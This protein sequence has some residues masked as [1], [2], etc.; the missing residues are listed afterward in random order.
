[1]VEVNP[2]SELVTPPVR[3]DD[4]ASTVREPRQIFFDSLEGLRGLAALW[5]MTY[6]VWLVVGLGQKRIGGIDIFQPFSMGGVGVDAFFVLS[7]FLLAI[8]WLRHFFQDIP[9]SAK[10]YARRRL[11][12]I[13][14]AYYASVLI[15]AIWTP[16][17][18]PGFGEPQATPLVLLAHAVF[19]PFL[20][21]APALDGVY[22]SLS[23][24]V[25]FYV[26]LPF[27]IYFMSIV[28]WWV[29]LGAL[30]LAAVAWHVIVELIIPFSRPESN[31]VN[32]NSYINST[33]LPGRI[34][35]F[36]I[37]IFI[38]FIWIRA[39]R[40][41]RPRLGAVLVVAGLLALMLAIRLESTSPLYLSAGWWTKYLFL[42]LGYGIAF[43]LIICGL[44]F[45]AYWFDRIC[46]VWP[47]RKLGTISYS[48]YLWHLPIATAIVAWMGGTGR[49]DHPWQAVALIALATLV[50]STASYLLV[51]RPF[52][53]G[54]NRALAAVRSVRAWLEQRPDTFRR[55]T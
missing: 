39:A 3:K 45:G 11:F 29:G 23:T 12:R 38:A 50:A 41:R 31:G 17:A 35:Q 32:L 21:N 26:S 7:G 18:A 20:A 44:V 42:R 14:P 22:W 48:V 54:G 15:L 51:E 1:M 37:G 24:E 36:A 33:L 8:P 46:S 34:G 13:A 10:K 2:T 52:L 27:L 47:I 40:P 16:P 9:V 28:R 4:Q 19:A 53:D 49:I 5:V 25:Q 30:M 6:H 55:V 43:G